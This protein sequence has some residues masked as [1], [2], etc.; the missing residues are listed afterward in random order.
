MNEL[1]KLY[2]AMLRSWNGVIKDDGRILLGTFDKEYPIR[3][4]EMDLY[5]PMSNIL[6]G[7]VI[8]KVFFHP[9]CENITSKETE[10]FKI[11]RKMTSM[12]LLEV[13]R[14]Y[15]GVLFGLKGTEKKSWRQETID[16]IEPFK[17]TKAGVRKE[18][19]AL[20]SRM[21]IE[22]E[23]DGLDNRFIHFVVTKGGGRSK[24]TG[25]RVYYK[26]RP[27]FPFYNEIVKRL[28]RSEGQ[29]DNQ[30]VELNNFTISR[31]ALKL[32]VHLFQ[33][34]IPAVNNPSDAEFESTTPVAARLISYLG[35]YSDIAEQ[36]NRVQNT[37][38]A[39][40]DKAGVYNID[41]S[42]AEHLEE[43]P[44]TYRQVPVMDYNSH[45]TQE[46]HQHQAMNRNDMAGMMSISSSNN[47]NNQ[48]QLQQHNN[49]QHQQ[50]N[51]QVGDFDLTPPPMQAGDRFQ[52]TEIDQQGGRVLHHAINQAGI[53]VL[54]Q[55]TRRGNLLQRSELNAMQMQNMAMMNNMNNMA[56]M[57]GMNGMMNG[58][59][60]PMFNNMFN[61]MSMMHQ[62]VTAGNVVPSVQADN[63]NSNSGPASW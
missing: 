1:N 3:I 20:F 21:H 30:T 16:L 7:N 14:Q 22:L 60:N 8:N 50:Q 56:G 5:L 43:L 32:A 59:M 53:P 63:Y 58:M 11:I 15:P 36:L 57:N 45:N 38:R 48:Q 24:I 62:P 52:R 9:A 29:S 10:I 40:F 26:T 12:K 49:Q 35:C 34:L 47:T 61:P 19:D 23:E 46:D 42:W 54:Y 27:T 18:L 33:S 25:E 41:L 4:D 6:D 51:M 17:T 44:E 55:C 31:S 39:E 13:F 28:A 37:F 2:A